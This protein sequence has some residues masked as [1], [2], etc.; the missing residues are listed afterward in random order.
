MGQDPENFS[1]RNQEIFLKIYLDI[2]LDEG[3]LKF[4]IGSRP[5]KFQP[6]RLVPVYFFRVATQILTCRISR[7]IQLMILFRDIKLFKEII[8]FL[9][10]SR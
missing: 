1:G 5:K 7:T 3:N 10:F 6:G 9:R 4:W 8:A 2:Q